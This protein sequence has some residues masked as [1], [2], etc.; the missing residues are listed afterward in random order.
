[1]ALFVSK[2][3]YL[4]FCKLF[5]S[6]LFVKPIQKLFIKYIIGYV[7]L[8]FFRTHR[9]DGYEEKNMFGFRFDAFLCRRR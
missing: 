2:M 9:R 3:V 4:S 5:I 1:M 7:V 6:N 8:I